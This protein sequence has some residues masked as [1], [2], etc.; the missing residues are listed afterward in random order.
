MPRRCSICDH[1]ERE[2]INAALVSGEAYRSIAKHFATSPEA[3]WRHK[4]D[5]LPASLAKAEE[6]KEV[7]HTDTLLAQVLALSKETTAIL[8]EARQGKEKDNELALK[9]IARAEKQIELQAKL[10]GELQEGTTVN[11]FLLPEWQQLRALVLDA[12]APHPQARLAV[13]HALERM[14]YANGLS[15]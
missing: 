4:A 3:M 1:A 11:V 13:A 7:A 5:H 10:L 2:A 6:A 15:T 12:L 14:P 9:A 8:K